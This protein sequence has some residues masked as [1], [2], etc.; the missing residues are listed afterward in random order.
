V[1]AQDRVRERLSYLNNFCTVMVY[2][3]WLLVASFLLLGCL[4]MTLYQPGMRKDCVVVVVVVVVELVGNLHNVKITSPYP[5]GGLL[6]WG[7]WRCGHVCHDVYNM[8]LSHW[9]DATDSFCGWSYDVVWSTTSLW[10]H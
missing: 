9:S 10:L 2:S 7:S 6:G 8:G 3:Y 5:P 1:G 4:L